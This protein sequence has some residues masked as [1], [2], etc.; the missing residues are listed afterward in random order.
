M[1]TPP[2]PGQITCQCVLFLPQPL[3]R[4]A[5]CPR[6][7]T[8]ALPLLY[9]APLYSVHSKP[10]KSFMAHKNSL[11]YLNAK[12]SIRPR[13][14]FERYFFRLSSRVKQ[15]GTLWNRFYYNTFAFSA[16]SRYSSSQPVDIFKVSRHRDNRE[17]ERK[18]MRTI[19][20][21]AGKF[22]R[23]GN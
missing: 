6:G 3:F 7:A 13:N 10:S 22:C 16:Y 20:Q 9:S 15:S 4:F 1:G 8:V 12:M 21:R 19:L 11:I 2:V 14:Y 18:K 5:G 17:F 23:R